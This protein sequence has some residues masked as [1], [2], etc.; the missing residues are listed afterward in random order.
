MINRSARRTSDNDDDANNSSNNIAINSSD[1]GLAVFRSDDDTHNA[2]A[3]TRSRK[4]TPMNN[5]VVTKR[6]LKTWT[7]YNLLSFLVVVTF[8]V[9]AVVRPPYGFMPWRLFTGAF[10]FSD[11]A[12]GWDYEGAWRVGL[13]SGRSP[14]AMGY[15][16]L[17]RASNPVLSCATVLDTN[18]SF[19]ADPFLVIPALARRPLTEQYGDGDAAAAVG[20]VGGDVGVSAVGG[21]SGNDDAAAAAAVGGGGSVN[22][23]EW[24]VFFEV[25]NVSIG[26]GDIGVAR[27]LDG[28][29]TWRGLGT[30]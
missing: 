7:V 29:I 11:D 17:Q 8:A 15:T 19:V 18:A 10:K 22:D 6:A 1:I 14:L 3:N 9:D 5:D 13:A 20:G 16:P 4:R 25:K 21:I 24:Y 30:V 28:G 12:C 26:R 27:S 23:D 2:A